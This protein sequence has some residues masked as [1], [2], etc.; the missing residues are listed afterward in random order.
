MLSPK[1]C[2]TLCDPMTIAGQDPLS[3]GF[4]R[5]QYWSE[6]PFPSPCDLPNSGTEPGSPALQADSLLS[7]PPEKPKNTGVGILSL[8]QRIFPTQ[9]SNQV[10]LHLQVDSLPAELSGNISM[11]T[12]D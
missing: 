9:E 6:L 7:E 10:L 3:M 1:L 5:Q 11:Y 8:L 4:S 12:N 2:L